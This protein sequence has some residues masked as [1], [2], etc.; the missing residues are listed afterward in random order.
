MTLTFEEGLDFKFIQ[1]L[2]E[3]YNYLHEVTFGEIW[4][5]FTPNHP[6]DVQDLLADLFKAQAFKGLVKDPNTDRNIKT[7]LLLRTINLKRGKQEAGKG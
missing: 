5:D 3:F 7:D 2:E 4:G 6:G 1:T